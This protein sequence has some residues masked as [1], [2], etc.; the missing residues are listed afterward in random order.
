M[1]ERPLNDANESDDSQIAPPTDAVNLSSA[2]PTRDRRVFESRVR[3]ILAAV[4]VERQHR[5]DRGRTP[6]WLWAAALVSSARPALIAASLVAAVSIPAVIA[7]GPGR[8]AA[9]GGSATGDDEGRIAAAVGIPAP[10]AKWIGSKHAP[11][12]G[13]LLVALGSREYRFDAG[14]AGRRNPEGKQ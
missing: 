9:T 14:G 12:T 1:N 7:F 2:D 10:L 5:V 11:S 13:E 8:P 6:R 4:M 3:A